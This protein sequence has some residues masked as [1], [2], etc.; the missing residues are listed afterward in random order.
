MILAKL[1][2]GL[3]NQMFQYAAARRLAHRH[4]SELR[5][6]ISW[7]ANLPAEATPRTFDLHHFSIRASLASADDLI[8]TDGV[9][10]AKPRDLPLALW[11]KIRPR[12]RFVAERHLHFDERILTLPDNVCLFGYWLSEKYFAD[13]ET[14]VRR[15]FTLRE[16]PEGENE[17]LMAVMQATP[18]V[19]LHVRRGD[20]VLN[21]ELNRIHGTCSPEYYAAAIDH[22]AARVPGA[23]FFV[24]S[25]DLEW[26]RQNLPLR[27]PAEYVAHNRGRHDHEDL[28]LMSNC[29]HHIIANSG[30]SWWGAWLNTRPD[31]IVC[32][33]AHWFA[34]AP[35]EE[36]DVL[37]PS[38]VK[39]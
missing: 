23:C 15:E 8:G 29:R 4:G 20:Y 12:F 25:D 27:H 26:A 17:R 18:S 10:N 16:P 33:P 36:K 32:A 30:F 24:F 34:H 1:R 19:S 35:Y 13:I 21:P 37:P 5:L 28:R 6:D 14:V 31:K 2:G 38:W 3:S 9:R 7:Y 39:L 22:V 11:R